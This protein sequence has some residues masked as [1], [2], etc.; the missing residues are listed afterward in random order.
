LREVQSSGYPSY[1]KF[2]EKSV[3][4]V[5]YDPSVDR[6]DLSQLPADKSA[7]LIFHSHGVSGWKGYKASAA[8][9][10]AGYK[11]VYFFRGGFAE[12]VAKGFPME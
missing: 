7:K 5:S 8:A 9:V 6:F 12:W 2:D 1:G 4:A 11:N 3:K 10:K